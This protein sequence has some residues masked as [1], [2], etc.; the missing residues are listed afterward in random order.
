MDKATAADK[1]AYSAFEGTDLHEWLRKRQV[2]RLVVGGLATEYCVLNTA[3]DALSLG[4]GVSLLTD[5]GQKAIDELRSLDAEI[6]CSEDI[7][8]D[9]A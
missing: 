6:E 2:S 9:Q 3:R 5:A 1:D 4:Y 7:L 8:D